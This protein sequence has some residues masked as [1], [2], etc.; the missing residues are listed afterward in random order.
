MEFFSGIINEAKLNEVISIS[1]ATIP[2]RECEF[3]T[4]GTKLNNET[5]VVFDVSVGRRRP[6]GCIIQA[7]PNGC[8][9]IIW[10]EHTEIP[11]LIIHSMSRSIISSGYAY[12]AKH[13]VSFM[14]QTCEPLVNPKGKH[15]LLKL[16]ERLNFY[17][18]LT[19]SSSA[20]N[21]AMVLGNG[22]NDIERLTKMAK[23][24][25][26]WKGFFSGMIIEAKLNEVIS[27]CDASSYNGAMQ[28]FQQENAIS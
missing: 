10:V 16:V 21:W 12:G 7:V 27:I 3:L 23:Y 15:N 5:M 1:D 18:G 25:N 22:F 28:V 26:K 13:R 2:T 19:T 8:L 14:K 9:K 17:G 24:I 20:Y 6:S 11:D 4:Y